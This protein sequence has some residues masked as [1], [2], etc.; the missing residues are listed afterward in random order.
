MLSPQVIFL[1]HVI[2]QQDFYAY[3]KKYTSLRSPQIILLSH[4]ICQKD[5]YAFSIN[6]EFDKRVV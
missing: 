3:S 5:F 4:V 6:C 2:C 1:C